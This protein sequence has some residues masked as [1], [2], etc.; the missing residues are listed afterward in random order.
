MV[1]KFRNA[2][3]KEARST[4]G[5]QRSGLRYDPLFLTY[6]LSD[7]PATGALPKTLRVEEAPSLRVVGLLHPM[8]EIEVEI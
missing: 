3:G 2:P 7:C 4:L 8:C 5:N 1:R 6:C